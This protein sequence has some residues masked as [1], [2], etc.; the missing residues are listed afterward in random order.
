MRVYI[1]IVSSSIALHAPLNASCCRCCLFAH[2]ASSS[3]SSLVEGRAVCNST[4]SISK[5][6]EQHQKQQQ[7]QLVPIG[8]VTRFTLTKRTVHLKTRLISFSRKLRSRS[9]PLPNSARYASTVHIRPFKPCQIPFVLGTSEN[10][11]T[12]TTSQQ[13]RG[14]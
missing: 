6:E 13:A 11:R 3:W 8:G 4:N 10:R 2:P 14:F 12:T 7:Q 9:L 1:S 5:P